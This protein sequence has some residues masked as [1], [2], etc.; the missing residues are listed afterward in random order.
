M[1]IDELVADSLASAESVLT[2]TEKELGVAVADI[3]AG[4]I[5]LAL[6]EDGSP[7]HTERPARRREQ[8]ARWTSRR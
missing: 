8:R 5:D 3:G 2:D 6:F 1:K 7:F 4:T